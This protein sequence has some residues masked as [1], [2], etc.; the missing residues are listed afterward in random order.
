LVTMLDLQFLEA[1]KWI[2]VSLTN[3]TI[4][5]TSRSPPRT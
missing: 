3:K 1:R 2:A 5:S 4:A